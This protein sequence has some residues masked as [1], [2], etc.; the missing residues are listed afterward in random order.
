MK[1][2]VATATNVS[3]SSWARHSVADACLLKMIF[4]HSSVQFAFQQLDVFAQF[5]RYSVHIAHF[6]MDIDLQYVCS[7]DRHVGK[8]YTRKPGPKVRKTSF[9]SCCETRLP[10]RTSTM[11]GFADATQWHVGW[12]ALTSVSPLIAFLAPWKSGW[13]MR[14]Q[15]LVRILPQEKTPTRQW[16]LF[17]G[18]ASCY[19]N[20][21]ILQE[22]I[23][24]LTF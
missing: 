3:W 22:E 24:G 1:G 16:M 11:F 2:N 4:T 19:F 13:N 8:N 7:V 10:G 15:H 12:G 21:R 14:L 23:D 20:W 6:L 18:V 17:P 5:D 9:W